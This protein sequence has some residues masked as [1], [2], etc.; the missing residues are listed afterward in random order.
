MGKGHEN[1]KIA[2][3]RLSA[4][5]NGIPVRETGPSGFTLQDPTI[6]HQGVMALMHPIASPSLDTL[7]EA[8]KK[9]PSKVLLAL[10]S[11]Q[12]PRNLGAI[13]RSA[14][15]AGVSGIILPKDRTAPLSA[16]AIK[17]SSGSAFLVDICR[18][19]N[20]ASTLSRLKQEGI[21]IYGAEK[22][23]SGSI[24]ETDFTFPLCLVM[25]SEEKGIRRLVKE[26]C[27]FFVSIPIRESVESLNVSVAAAVILF[28]IN[29]RRIASSLL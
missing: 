7:V 5:E 11:I 26:E 18:V 24:Y 2:A 14:A 3:I 8:V 1:P 27:D 10:D 21:W 16:T 19:T 9:S 12:D 17:A 15:A 22:N 13:I 29:R 6:N 20:L 28:E 4:G 23:P 25:G